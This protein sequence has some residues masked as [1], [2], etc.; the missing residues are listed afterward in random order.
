MHT[1]VVC[2]VY[3]KSQTPRKNYYMTATQEFP[4]TAISGTQTCLKKPRHISCNLC[5][6]WIKGR[7]W[8][9]SCRPAS[10]HVCLSDDLP[11]SL[12]AGLLTS[13]FPPFPPPSSFFDIHKF[14]LDI[15]N[16][17]WISTNDNN[18]GYR[19]NNYGYQ[20]IMVYLGPVTE[21]CMCLYLS[22]YPT[23][24]ALVAR[25]QAASG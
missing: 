11:A 7:N 8:T 14:I 16:Y 22:N 25:R 15:H 23:N 17:L 19:K 4:A 10:L 20:K 1:C 9:Y 13:L 5:I 6:E 24:I 2:Y 18:F 12:P 3:G 21:E